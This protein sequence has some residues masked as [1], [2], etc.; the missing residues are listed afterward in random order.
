MEKKIILNCAY[1]KKSFEREAREHRRQLKEG[2]D[3]FYC[4]LSCVC[5]ERNKNNPPK[6]NIE[7]FKDRVKRKDQYTPFRWFILRAEYRGKRKRKYGCDLTVEFLKKL[8][9]EQN[10]I[11]PLTG[12]QLKLPAG[13]GIAWAESSPSNASLDRIDN[14]KGYVEGNVRF[15]AY[16][17]NIAR[18]SFSD[19]QLKHFCKAVVNNEMAT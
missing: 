15:I 9:E 4:S 16:M 3:I 12:W 11:C 7:N 18:Q 8:W 17:A 6:G 19:E 13:T 14:S 2:K 10:G 1:C 5:K